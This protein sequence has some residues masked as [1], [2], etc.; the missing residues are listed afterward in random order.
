[1]LESAKDSPTIQAYLQ[2]GLTTWHFIPERAPHFGGLWES[3]VRAAKLHLKK[4]VGE[5]ILDY[6]EMTTVVSQVEACLNSRPLGQ[7]YSHSADAVA[8]LTPAHF[9]IGRSMMAYPEPV[10][11]I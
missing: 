7:V 9:L 8:P 2:E 3:A 10:Q 6:E 5:Q 11:L 1:M 4:V